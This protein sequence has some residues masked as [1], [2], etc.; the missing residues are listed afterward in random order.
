M[1]ALAAERH[2]DSKQ[3][4]RILIAFGQLGKSVASD[5]VVRRNSVNP[6]SMYARKGRVELTDLCPLGPT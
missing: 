4:I 6:E 1:V 3:N 2:H 5:D